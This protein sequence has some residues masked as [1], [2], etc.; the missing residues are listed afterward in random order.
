MRRAGAA[1]AAIGALAVVAIGLDRAFPPDLSRLT[2]LGSRVD[3]ASGQILALRP[4]TGGVWKFRTQAE[5]VPRFLRDLLVDIEDRHFDVHPGIDPIAAVRALWLDVRA[6]HVVSGGSTLTMQ[7]ARLLTPHRRTLGGKVIEGL[8]A[9]Q[10]SER[11]DKDAILGMWLSLAPFGGNLVGV[12]AA[13]RAYFGKPPAALDPAEAALLVALPRRPEALRPDRH[14]D[15][16]RVLRDRI[17]LR[18]ERDGLLDQAETRTAMA[19]SVP[20]RRVTM[21]DAAPMLFAR[22]R[23]DVRTTLDGALQLALQ[24]ASRDELHRLPPRVSLAVVIADVRSRAVLAAVAGD[25]GNAERA[26]WMDL[27]RRVRSPGSA[28]KPFLYALAFEDGLAGP[29][30]VLPD[31]PR[32]FAGYAPEDFSH[33]FSGGTRAADALRRSLN[34][35][36]VVLLSRY[37]PQRFVAALHD[38]GLIL[39]VDATASLPVILG[40]A[41]ITLHD[42][43][44]LYAALGGD[45]RLTPLRWLA[46]V[47]RPSRVLLSPDSAAEVADILTRPFPGGGPAGIAWKTGTSAGNRDSWALGFDRAHVVGV[48]IGRPDGSARP[49]PAAADIALPVLARVFALLPPHP[50]VVAPVSRMASLTVPAPPDTLTLLFPPPSVTLAGIGPIELRAQGGERPL[51]FLVDGAVVASVPALRETRWTPLGPGFYD[52]AVLDSAGHSARAHVRVVS[53]DA[54]AAAR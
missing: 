43:T 35:P 15:R 11:F 7:V 19:E 54:E 24:A 12:A 3:D 32:R 37:G 8:R 16:A 6:G 2:V 40:G 4:A 21:P 42:L 10:L 27:T 33:R 44:A 49:G 47:A 9:L 50:R 25:A 53:D 22:E 1:L 5:Q 29:D 20:R 46:G 26:G 48:W 38:A 31:G 14:P 34:L 23:G 52:V 28:L 13:S 39:P 36:A 41:G 17:L 30:T 18:A 45:G 51:T